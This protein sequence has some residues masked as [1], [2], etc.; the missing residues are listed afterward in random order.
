M[1]SVVWKGDLHLG[2]D[3]TCPIKLVAAAR[4]EKM[5]FSSVNPATGAGV[6]VINTDKSTGEVMKRGDLVKSTT[7]NGQVVYVTDEEIKQ[8]VP[9]DEEKRL[10]ISEFVKL[11]EVDPIYFDVS[12]Y[13]LPQD[14]SSAHAYQMVLQA[15]ASSKYCAIGRM[16]RS[17]R[18]YLVL[19]RPKG[20]GLVLHT[21]FY[22][23]E[24]R[25]DGYSSPGHLIAEA[26][27]KLCKKLVRAR[28]APFQP[29]KYKDRF[30]E[31]LQ[32]LL[33][34]KAAS[35]KAPD[36]KAKL[37][38]AVKKAKKARRSSRRSK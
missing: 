3:I 2:F 14:D 33:E 13:V 34:A 11:S 24:V 22:A 10:E 29:G 15:L 4:E 25:N 9:E 27:V 18:E 12:Y 38:T 36:L 17:K 5:S 26:E 32:A 37:K 8:L 19:I 35:K 28:S 20:L 21:L 31:S 23:H 16:V 7:V 30:A 6:S 1:A